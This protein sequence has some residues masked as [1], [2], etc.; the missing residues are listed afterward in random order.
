MS[1]TTILCVDDDPHILNALKRVLRKEDYA[2]LTA[3][4]VS[5]GLELL[6]SRPVQIVISDQRMPE[7][8]GVEF[9]QKV[10]DISS[11][12]VRCI[13]S[14]YADAGLIV[15]SIN[16][17]EVFRFLTKPWNDDELRAT[18]R[19][20]LAHYDIVQQN[21]S[22]H[23][24]VR[25]QNQKLRSLNIMMEEVVDL[26]TRSLELAQEV[27]ENLPLAVIGISREGTVVLAN[28][29]A[30][31]LV[32]SLRHLSPGADAKDVL[33]EEAARAVAERLAGETAP[34]RV[35]V[36][37]NNKRLTLDIRTLCYRDAIRGCMVILNPATE[38]VDSRSEL[39]CK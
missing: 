15:D 6:R 3:E 35:A 13:L 24:Q 27:F 20:C 38:V 14:G 10:K 29:A 9:L 36:D 7:M 5:R 11:D 39:P 22:L 32:S 17:G 2:V 1:D 25:V 26:R 23:D 37:W 12:T 31:E 8:S 16:K 34:G 18:I 28:H 21:R 30:E 33:P 4:S 19:Q